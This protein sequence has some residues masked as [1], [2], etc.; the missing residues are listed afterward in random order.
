MDSG[1]LVELPWW[2]GSKEYTQS[3]FLSQNKKHYVYP[4]QPQFSY[5]KWGFLACSIIT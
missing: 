5:A 1:Y 3:M 4:N 2:G